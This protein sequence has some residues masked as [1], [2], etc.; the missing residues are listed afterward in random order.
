MKKRKKFLKF[1]IKHKLLS[2]LP[3]YSPSKKS[4]NKYSYTLSSNI[5][6]TSSIYTLPATALTLQQLNATSFVPRRPW[7]EKKNMTWNNSAIIDTI[8]YLAI[9]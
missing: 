4:I 6:V 2:H 5:S 3:T 7:N 9:E 1:K 8:I